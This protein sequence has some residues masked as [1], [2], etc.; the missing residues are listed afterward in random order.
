MGTDPKR[1]KT[2]VEKTSGDPPAK[3]SCKSGAGKSGSDKNPTSGGKNGNAELQPASRK[4][5]DGKNEMAALKARIAELEAAAAKAT[6]KAGDSENGSD[7]DKEGE[8]RGRPVSRDK[9][10]HQTSLF[11]SPWMQAIAIKVNDAPAAA[12]LIVTMSIAHTAHRQLVLQKKKVQV[13]T[14][15]TIIHCAHHFVGPG[16][17]SNN[18]NSIEL[19]QPRR[20]INSVVQIPKPRKKN[21]SLQVEMG[22][23]GSTKKNE[24]YKALKRHLRDLAN[25][26]GI[27]WW[28][29]WSEIPAKSKA[30][31]F[32][33][34]TL[35]QA[36]T[37]HPILAKFQNDWA[38]EKIV[39]QYFANKR[40]T[41]YRSGALEVPEKYHYLKDNAA[42]RDQSKS[43]KKLA[44]VVH[45]NSRSE[46]KRA[47]RA[48]K[49]KDKEND[50]QPTKR[51]RLQII[52]DDEA[53]GAAE[54]DAGEN[55]EQFVHGLSNDGAAAGGHVDEEEG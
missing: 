32:A 33:L 44:T 54:K 40:G 12:A 21:W 9:K 22:L 3:P 23:A 8:V 52:N 38:T 15:D 5:K 25:G 4:G 36:R 29:D 17:L 11:F 18:E 50:G 49:E 27:E 37:E 48:E 20:S 28:K 14:N 45:E 51:R 19:P 26:S 53:E 46:R 35:L 55:A 10:I 43:R 39:C 2:P 47:L 42:Q 16:R 13:E 24:V 34:L 31:L 30:D 6:D 41:N 7:E 1:K